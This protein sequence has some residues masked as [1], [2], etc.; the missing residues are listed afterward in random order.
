LHESDAN[1]FQQ[2]EMV[3][4]FDRLRLIPKN[5][6][7]L[8]FVF[9]NQN[10]YIIIDKEAMTPDGLLSNVGG[11]LSLWLGMTVMFV[12][13]IVEF[14][15]SIISSRYNQRKVKA[16]TANQDKQLPTQTARK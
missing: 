16:A 7:Q 6:I 2:E 11:A 12:F 4:K 9:E 1:V 8:N 13:E 10:P 15:Q 5:F 3:T 14:I